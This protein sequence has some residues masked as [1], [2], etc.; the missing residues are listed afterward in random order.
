MLPAII[1]Y[2]AGDAGASTTTTTT[3]TTTNDDDN[4]NNNDIITTDN[5]TERFVRPEVEEAFLRSRIVY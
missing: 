5:K 4:N 2:A 1:T 3:T